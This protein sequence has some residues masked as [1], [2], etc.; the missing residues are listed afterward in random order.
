MKFTAPGCSHWHSA[1]AL[2]LGA[3]LLTTAAVVRADERPFTYVQEAEVLPKG[4]LAFEQWL[5]HRRGKVDGEFS[6][7]DFREELEYGLADTLSVAG[8]L[9]F[10]STHSEGVT[11]IAN[12]DNLAFEG[13][14]TELKYQLSNPNLKP[15]GALLYGEARYNG[16]E[17]EL[18][19]RLAVQRNFGEKWTVA[20]NAT[21]EEEWEFMPTDT[22]EALKLELTA[23][24]AYKISSHWS[25]GI[26]GRNHRE[27]APGFSFDNHEHSA[28]F[29]GPNLHYARNHWWATL[30]VLPQV[31]GSPSTRDGLQLEAHEKIEVRLIAG[32]NL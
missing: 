31:R 1:R 8:Y 25:V 11:G 7:W 3:A 26:E 22:G 15:L 30:T 23:G 21:L 13:V 18:E 32:I 2:F 6:S 20:L 24:V 5:T 9:N 28:W 16:H 19:Q 14:S 29:V 12:E 10:K 4:G 27:F 17:F